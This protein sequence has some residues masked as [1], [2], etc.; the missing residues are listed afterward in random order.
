M[1]LEDYRFITVLLMFL[2]VF[3]WMSIISMGAQG[4]PIVGIGETIVKMAISVNVTQVFFILYG[5]F[6]DLK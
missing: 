2:G 3:L 1:K 5:F 6:G 4:I